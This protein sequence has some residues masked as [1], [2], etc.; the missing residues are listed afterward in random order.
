MKKVVPT[1]ILF[2]I[3]LLTALNMFSKNRSPLEKTYGGAGNDYGQ[4]IVATNDGGA[5]I[6]GNTTSFGAG[7]FDLWLLKI[8]SRGD[9]LWS[10]TYGGRGSD[11]GNSLVVTDDGGAFI[12]GRT[13]SFGNGGSDLWLLRVDSNGD[14]LWTKTYGE[15]GDENSLSMSITS[16]GGTL[17]A[18]NITPFAKNVSN[19]WLLRTTRN[20]DLLWSKSFGGSKQDYSKSSAL[21]SDN[22]AIITGYTESFGNGGKDLWLLRIDSSGDT[23]WSKSY[24]GIEDEEGLSVAVTNDGGALISGYRESFDNGDKDLWLLRVNSSGDTLW[25]KTFGDTNIDYG[26]S[27]AL[28]DDG[29]ALITGFSRSFGEGDADLWILRVN[30]SGDTLWTKTIGGKGNDRGN[31]VTIARNKRA[32]ITG[33]TYSSKTGNSNLKFWS[34][35]SF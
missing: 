10:K 24:G 23:L 9:T 15:A 20:G 32:F 16:D 19:I 7:S 5:F 4:A 14:T 25:T 12:V 6:S 3:I 30:S 28:F 1:M 22:G 35:N 11:Y 8:D 31:A 21:Y 29:G 18:G 34:L 2:T 13:N 33:G 26:E 27:L 17:I